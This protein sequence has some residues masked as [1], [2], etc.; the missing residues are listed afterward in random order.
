MSSPISRCFISRWRGLKPT[1]NALTFF[2][3]S[4]CRGYRKTALPVGA[5]ARCYWHNTDPN[6]RWPLSIRRCSPIQWTQPLS[7]FD[8]KSWTQCP[9]DTKLKTRMK[10]LFCSPL[11]GVA[12]LLSVQMQAASFAADKKL[13]IS[14][15]W[16]FSGELAALDALFQATKRADPGIE[17]VNATFA[18]GG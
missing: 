7:I 1:P 9:D 18:G 3:H 13:E 8:S 6:W 5:P 16:S 2:A 4:A 17:I 10:K 15:Y 11:A 14:T 12:L